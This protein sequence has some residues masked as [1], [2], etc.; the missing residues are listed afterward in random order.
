MH[1]VP[2]TPALAD[3]PEVRSGHLWL[4]ELVDGTSLRAQVREAAPM[5]FGD[6]VRPFDAGDAPRELRYA[7]HEVQRRLDR[8]ALRQAVD[9][10]ESITFVGVATHRRRVDYDWRRLP[11]FLGT[12]VWDDDT[13]DFLPPDRAE[14]VFETLDL[15]PVNALEKEVRATDFHP[16][17][18]EFPDS[19]WRDG[20]AAGLIVRN[21]T[22]GLARLPNPDVLAA[23]DEPVA[24]TVIDANDPAQELADRFATPERFERAASTL[25]DEYGGRPGF[26]ALQERVLDGIYREHAPVF[27]HASLDHDAFRRAVAARTSEFVGSR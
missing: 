14:Q 22:G 1:A 10:V 15:A 24:P 20:P 4:Q 9:D 21:K 3:A 7:V 6:D 2:E 5:R 19:A 16:D 25:A 23:P 27:E 13:G 11:G 12:D 8:T 17:R 18:Y 26:D